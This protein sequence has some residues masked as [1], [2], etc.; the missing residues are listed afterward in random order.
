MVGFITNRRAFMTQIGDN[1]F[2]QVGQP[3]LITLVPCVGIA[4]SL[5]AV[6]N[7]DRP[8]PFI[9]YEQYIP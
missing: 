5:T 6:P 2:G 7:H 9:R 3:E 1:I 8:V 4:R